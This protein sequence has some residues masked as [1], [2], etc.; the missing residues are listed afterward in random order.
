MGVKKKYEVSGTVKVVFR[1]QVQVENEEE[2]ARIVGEDM[3][4]PV[5][6]ENSDA[7]DID[8]DYVDEVKK[9]PPKEKPLIG[10]KR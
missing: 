8:V 7:Y 3:A 9:S 2:A 5:L 4:F 10:V 1:V 6:I